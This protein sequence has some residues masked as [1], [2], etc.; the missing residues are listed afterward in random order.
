MVQNKNRR[1]Y[2]HTMLYNLFIVFPSL[3]FITD[4]ELQLYCNCYIMYST[5]QSNQPSSID[6][7]HNNYHINCK[8]PFIKLLIIHYNINVITQTIVLSSRN[9]PGALCKTLLTQKMFTLPTSKIH[10][11]K[12]FKVLHTSR[13]VTEKPHLQ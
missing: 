2:F 8:L 10:P 12:P 11:N 5:E 7:V 13:L 4:H 6:I 1:L 3:L 9:G